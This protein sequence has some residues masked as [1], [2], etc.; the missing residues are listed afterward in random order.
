MS[1]RFSL[2]L[3][4]AATLVTGAAGAHAQGFSAGISPSKFELRAAPGEI[5]RDT[6]AI[7]N[8]SNDPADYEL[9]TADWR[10]SST[11]GVEFVEDSL[12]DG[13]CRPWVRLERRT[14]RI[15]AGS[16]R[17]YRFEVHVPEDAPAG[18]CRFAIVIEPAE[19]VMTRIG[20]GA[21][22][23]SVP[24]VGRYAIVTYV[25][26]GDASP[27]IEL[28]DIG[29][30]DNNG[31]R[32]PAVTLRNTGNTYDRAIG[33]LTAVD[34]SGERVLLV[35]ASFPVLPGRTE[36]VAIVPDLGP[37]ATEAIALRFPLRL[38]GNIEIGGQI[39]A[40]DEVLE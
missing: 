18:L 37:E 11:G 16:Q 3:T 14:L 36:Q 27:T 32:F 19:S 17:N 25:T 29:T 13:S 40:I 10:L 33:Q 15:N 30:K 1:S 26:I 34:F 7:L 6:I 39:F 38:T 23:I 31:Q 2:R 22:A 8:P 20:E 28:V 24:I 21:A 9:K 5:L 35:P 4:L 12:L